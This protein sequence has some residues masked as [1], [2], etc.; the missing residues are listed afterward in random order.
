MPGITRNSGQDAAGGANIEGS[1][2]VFANN[3]PV[4]R[5]GDLVAGHGTGAH[6]SP[7]MASGSAN[8]FTNNNKTCKAGDIASCGHPSSGSNDVFVND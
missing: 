7:V 8:V 6:A 3:N 4:V 1:S 5:V 2:N